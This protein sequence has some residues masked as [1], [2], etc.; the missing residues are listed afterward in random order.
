MRKYRHY[1]REFKLSLL[2]ELN[3]KS[4]VEVSREHDIHPVMLSKWKK[5]LAENPGK[6][7]AGNGNICHYEAEIAK[8]DRLI[9]QLCLENDL[10]KKTAIRLQELN[11]EEK[12]MKRTK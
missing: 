6:A 5:E 3:F 9:G 11:A 8:R 7:F 4:A 12:I 2:N 10:L 1:T